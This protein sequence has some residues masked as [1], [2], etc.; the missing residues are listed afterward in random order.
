MAAQAA[1]DPDRG[2]TTVAHL[3]GEAF[4]QEAYRQTRQSSAAGLEGVT[5]RAYPVDRDEN[6]RDWHARLRSGR[7]Q[8]VPVARVWSEKD[9]GGQRPIGKPAFE[10]KRVPRAVARLLEAIDE[11][12]VYDR[13]YGFRRGRSPHD[14]RHERR[15]R[16]M[17]E[18]SRRPDASGDRHRARRRHLPQASQYIPP[19][20]LGGMG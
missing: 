2:F 11:R 5:A 18:G 1:R 17:M 20:G 10:G 3:L 14:A 13:S 4:R 16:G 7:S 8:A 9:D 6:R 12:D 15:A 19:S